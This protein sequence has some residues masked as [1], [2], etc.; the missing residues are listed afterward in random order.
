MANTVI[1]LTN[2]E[3]DN[4]GNVIETDIPNPL[5]FN[6]KLFVI[7]QPTSVAPQTRGDIENTGIQTANKNKSH[8]CDT[9]IYVDRAVAYAKAMGG[10]LVLAIRNAIKAIM[11]AL[12]INPGSNGLIEFLKKVKD[13]ADEFNTW[14]KEIQNDINAFLTSVQKIQALI[15]YI[16][17]LPG[18]LIKYFLGCIKEAY[19]EL[20][21][22]FLQVIS[23]VGGAATDES[24]ELTDSLKAAYSSVKTTV[25]TAIK[26]ATTVAALPV[27]TVGT[28]L[29]PGNSTVA[30]QQAAAKEAG[31]LFN[32]YNTEQTFN[33]P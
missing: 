32:P 2:I 5:Y 25:G 6:D 27:T 31:I 9:T 7:D 8:V 33:K 4:Y 3:V 29:S 16:L 28:L 26:T 20:S 14:L 17:S 13:Y 22:A 15:A 30:Q 19:A 18:E 1:Q 12:G 11:K 23:D 10:Q 21:A 24:K